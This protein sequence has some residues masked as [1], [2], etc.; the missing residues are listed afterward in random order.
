M[1]HIKLLLHPRGDYAF[2][3]ER[4]QWRKCQHTHNNFKGTDSKHFDMDPN[5][6]SCVLKAKLWPLIIVTGT[7]LANESKAIARTFFSKRSDPKGGALAGSLKAARE[8]APPLGTD[9]FPVDRSPWRFFCSLVARLHWTR[10]PQTVKPVRSLCRLMFLL[11]VSLM[12]L[13][14]RASFFIFES[15]RMCR[16][17]T[18]NCWHLALETRNPN[19]ISGGDGLKRSE[20]I[21]TLIFR[22]MLVLLSLNLSQ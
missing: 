13:G 4:P 10:W 21:Y 15:S 20:I 16:P 14:Q 7:F 6:I 5:Y 12:F 18:R 8:C 11:T 17:G 22:C 3:R 19:L 1:Q 9:L 2:W